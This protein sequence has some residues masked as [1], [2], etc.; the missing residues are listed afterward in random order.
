MG[1]NSVKVRRPA[2]FREYVNPSTANLP[3][4]SLN[5]EVRE[6]WIDGRRVISS[7]PYTFPVDPDLMD[8][9]DMIHFL[10]RKS[11][12]GRN[13]VVPLKNPKRILD[14]GAGGGTWAKEMGD[15]FPKAKIYALELIDDI[16]NKYKTP[17]NVIWDVGNILDG[18]RYE[19]NFFD[20]VQQRI[21]IGAIPN[22][23][24]QGVVNEYFR[25]TKRGGWTCLID[26]NN[27]IQNPG[28]LLL[29][30]HPLL[31][32]LCDRSNV[33]YRMASHYEQYLRNAGFVD[34]RVHKFVLKLGSWA[35]DLGAVYSDVLMRIN[36]MLPVM[37]PDMITPE[38][39]IR[40][41]QDV[42]GEEVNQYRS[43]FE[44]VFAW[45]RKP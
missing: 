41:N 32:E 38:E 26:P 14:A 20:F 29:E 34:I 39:A 44:F 30:W 13:Y 33:N 45:G 4:E 24:I 12:D 36:L 2:I 35:G 25:I 37:L 3:E 28:P 1:N 8:M 22:D 9:N 43:G 19:D 7:I 42:F 6:E 23:K 40:Y 27:Y 17:P 18:T 10:L 21:L 31:K 16:Y 5:S 11:I 15:E